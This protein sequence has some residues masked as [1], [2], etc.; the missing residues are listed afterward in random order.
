MSSLSDTLK[1][2]EEKLEDLQ[3]DTK[4]CVNN[5]DY[6]HKNNEN[7]ILE[8]LNGILNESY[9]DVQEFLN[10]IEKVRVLMHTANKKCSEVDKLLKDF[11]VN[12]EIIDIATA[13]N[14]STTGN[15]FTSNGSYTNDN[16]KH[17]DNLGDNK[18]NSND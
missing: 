1:Q 15:S 5:Y 18:E 6:H 9:Q 14:E 4:F 11:G 13:T 10:N 16:H 3:R 12:D 7:E 2:L 17:C 8:Q